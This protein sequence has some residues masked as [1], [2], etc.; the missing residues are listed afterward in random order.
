VTKRYKTKD[1]DKPYGLT[2]HGV[3][4]K[5]PGRRKGS[6]KSPGTGRSKQ[7][8]ELRLDAA[9]DELALAVISG[10]PIHQYGTTGKA[11]TA[12]ANLSLR[13]KFAE[14]WWNRRR[15]TLTATAVKADVTTEHVKTEPKDP[16]QVA[17]AVLTVLEHAKLADEPS[18]PAA[19]PA[20]GQLLL[21]RDDVIEIAA[22]DPRGVTA[23]ALQGEASG[24]A[25]LLDAAPDRNGAAREASSDHADASPE[26]NDGAD[27]ER[28]IFDNGAEVIYDAELG[29]FAVLDSGGELHGYRRSRA[30]AETFAAILPAPAAMTA[31]GQKRT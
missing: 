2:R 19:W 3:P 1:K 31:V 12:P 16:R 5:R 23:A 30:L 13:Q 15:P 24:H 20:P 6:A 8:I 7:P 27:G 29:K 17:R 18:D 11:F 26:S 21:G 9:S 28:T 10:E 25:E 14:V 4:R 22:S